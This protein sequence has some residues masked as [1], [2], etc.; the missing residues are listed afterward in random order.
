MAEYIGFP[1]VPDG[2]PSSL[3]RYWSP[4]YTRC[5]LDKKVTKNIKALL[6]EKGR[7]VV[8]LYAQQ[9][10]VA[11]GS[12]TY[13]DSN[14]SWIMKKA[15]NKDRETIMKIPTQSFTWFAFFMPYPTTQWNI[16]TAPQLCSI[17]MFPTNFFTQFP[18][19]I[20]QW[21]RLHLNDSTARPN[22]SWHINGK[23]KNRNN[24]C[25]VHHKNIE[26]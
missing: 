14:S 7:E 18:M 4:N 6:G 26:K 3:L 12:R 17:M 21:E 8:T 22:F 13:F 15:K 20:L 11:L 25:L 2:S 5:P 19:N 10:C 1:A 9:L 24:N 23:G 16:G